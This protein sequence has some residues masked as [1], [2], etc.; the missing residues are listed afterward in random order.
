MSK[1]KKQIIKMVLA[2]TLFCSA[3]VSIGLEK[4]E[5]P[6]QIK[7]INKKYSFSEKKKILYD[8][9]VDLKQNHG[10][11]I[12]PS[13]FAEIALIMLYSESGLNP[14]AVSIDGYQSQGINQLTSATRKKLGIPDNILEDDFPKQVEYFKSFLIST[15]KIN[16]IDNSVTLHLLNFA[17]SLPLSRRDSVCVA[18]G[19]L[20]H[21]D[22]NKN[23]KIDEGDFLEFQ[24]QRTAE[25][26]NLKTIF[27][28]HYG[29]AP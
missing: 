13:K 11:R 27:E 4:Q 14:K 18:K 16:K 19:G 6:S 26:K 2:T 20:V 24:R 5:I 25:H 9:G 7:I 28:K 23:G 1:T 22:I 17:P 29:A 10:L 15:K 3:P 12:S 8:L 21:L